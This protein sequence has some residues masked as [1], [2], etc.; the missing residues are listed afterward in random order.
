MLASLR[1]SVRSGLA[2]LILFVALLALV[3]TGFGT[4]GIGGLDSLSSRGGSE[5]LARV[6]GRE[7]S[8]EEVTD[9]VNRQFASAR[10]QQPELDLGTYAAEAY[11]PIDAKPCHHVGRREVLRDAAMVIDLRDEAVE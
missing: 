6:D 2:V 4:G 7:L 5:A 1:R 3:I 10:Q 8:A 9:I 11:E